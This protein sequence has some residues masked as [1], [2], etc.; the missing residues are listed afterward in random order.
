MTR[1]FWT[2]DVPRKRRKG[3]GRESG[4]GLAASAEH[5]GSSRSYAAANPAARPLLQCPVGL[6]GAYHSCCQQVRALDA[7]VKE[8]EAILADLRGE[9][10]G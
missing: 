7:R 1:A 2:Y 5:D 4:N 8:L 3:G 10:R 6:D 9:D